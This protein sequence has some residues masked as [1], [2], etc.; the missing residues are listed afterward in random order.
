MTAPRTERWSSRRFA[1]R[2]AVLGS[3]AMLGGCGSAAPTFYALAPVNG[4]TGRN[5]PPVI[6][7]RAPSVAAFL[8]RDTIVSATSDYTAR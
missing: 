8:D 3:L 6:E 5:A 4:A 7:V 2:S 1:I